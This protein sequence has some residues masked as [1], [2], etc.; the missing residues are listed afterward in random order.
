MPRRPR[1]IL[2]GVPLHVIQRGNNRE[3]CFY[4]DD[5]C[6]AYLG[7]LEEYARHSGCAVH[8]YVLMT[9]HVHILLTPRTERSAGDL[10]KRLGQRYVQYVN[11]TYRRSGTLW[12]GRFRSCL[13]GEEGYVLGCCRYIELNPVRANMVAHPGEYP[14]SSYRSNGQGER[15]SLVTPHPLYSALGPDDGQR[16]AAYRELFRFHLDPGFVGQPMAT[17]RWEAR[18]FRSRLPQRSAGGQAAAGLDGRGNGKLGNRLR[19]KSW[20]VPCVIKYKYLMV[21]RVQPARKIRPS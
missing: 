15:S 18:A 11:R 19:Q 12:E 3:A 13:T 5:D 14:W 21:Y 16:Q 17:M 20:S 9:N 6:S 2:P 8:A 10:M 7:W 1:I 4:A